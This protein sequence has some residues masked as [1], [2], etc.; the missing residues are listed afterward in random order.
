M[1]SI[2]KKVTSARWVVPLWFHV[3]VVHIKMKLQRQNVKSA[4]QVSIISCGKL[5]FLMVRFE[6]IRM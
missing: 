6:A 1:R 5:S 4:L 2:V 3:K